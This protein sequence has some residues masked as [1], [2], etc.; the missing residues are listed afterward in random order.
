MRIGIEASMLI[1]KNRR[2]ICNSVIELI[3]VWAKEYPEHEY[4]LIARAPIYLD[5]N[6]PSN[7]HIVDNEYKYHN[8]VL[9]HYYKK[10]TLVKKY[11]IDVFWSSNLAIKYW[12]LS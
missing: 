9:W 10:A 7:W 1:D 3:N 12:S 5:M 4:F 6:L 11:K 8:K 2:G